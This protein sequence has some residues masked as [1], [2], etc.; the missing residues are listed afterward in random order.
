MKIKSAS[1]KNFKTFS[2]AGIFFS[3][4]DLTAL[5]GENSVGKSN[6]LEG[7]DLFFNFSKSKIFINSFHHDN[8]LRPIVI[9]LTFH[10][11]TDGESRIF[12]SHL[13]EMGNLTVTQYIECV[14]TNDE[15]PLAEANMD[16]ID[17]IESK[18]G[19]KLQPTTEYDWTVLQD[20]KLPT[21][22]NVK[23]WWKKELK[24]GD[25]D[26]KT[27]FNSKDEPTQ[28]VY[29]EKLRLLWNE[30]SGNIPQEQITGDEKM[31]GWKS[32]LKANLPKYFYIPAIKNVAD[33]LKNT[34]SSALGELINWISSSVSKEIKN[35]FKVK[36]TELVGDLLKKI[37]IDDDGNSKIGMINKALNEN[38]GFDIGCSLELK[39]GSPEMDDLIFP[40][41]KVYGNDGYYSEITEKGHGIQRLALFSLLRTYNTFD[42]GKKNAE[43]NIIIGIEEPEI[44]LHPP[45]KRSTYS[46]LQRISRGDDQVIYCTHDSLFLS[47]EFFDE[48]R[49]FRKS[50]GN[51]PET[52]VYEFSVSQLV[53]F[54][55]KLYGKT[56]DEK[57]IRH[58]FYHIIDESKNEGFFA[59][60]VVLIEGDT[61][62]YAL[63][64]YF[65]A[66]GFNLDVN[67]VAIISAGSV[68]NISYLL[69]IFNEFRVPCYV[70]FDG[71]KPKDEPSTYTDSS[72]DDLINK[73]IRNK[74]LFQ[75]LNKPVTNEQFFFPATSVDQN[76]TVWERNFEDEFHRSLVNYNQLKSEA[77][78]LYGNDSKPLTARYISEKISN[79]PAKI[80]AK[81]DS[82]I[83]KLKELKWN[84]SIVE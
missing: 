17:F 56:I 48:I 25:F 67:R 57:S 43:K 33:D 30:Y 42:F 38:V 22:A 44:Y 31:L 47:V 64:N 74:E 3:L 21:K 2:E 19:T 63:P 79:D 50:D 16:E 8:Y 75:L 68:D 55:K 37:D 27:L 40:E 69:L 77:K 9:E 24:V 60:K 26:F 4:N 32:K 10:K 72:R 61:E 78:K 13:D 46:L 36:S 34:K 35:E 11:L 53:E 5:I 83:N 73:S 6:V 41:P 76:F 54:Y 52:K 51:N 59:K 45:L 29:V 12:K 65:K 58:R 14:C 23:A 80:D 71:D 49:M 28:E 82:M 7:I 62:K 81:I 15:K 66:K 1:F 20:D 39:F 18:H 84:K 70:I